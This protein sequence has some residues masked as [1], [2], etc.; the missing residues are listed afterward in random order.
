VL[1]ALVPATSTARDA[2]TLYGIH[3]WGHWEDD[4]IDTEPA[5][6]FDVPE[7]SGWTLETVLTHSGVDWWR[8][9]YFTP[10]YRKLAR[11]NVSIIT[12]VDYSWTDPIPAPTDPNYD[13]WPQQVSEQVVGEL[14]DYS[15]FWKI[16]NEP[17]IVGGEG[18][19]WPDGKIPPEEY[20]KAYR[21]VRAAIHE[22]AAGLEGE[23]VVLL[24]GP[25]PGEFFEEVR[26]MAGN[27]YLE[28]VIDAIP[29][30]EIDG[31]AIHAYGWDVPMFA[32]G[33]Q[34][35][36]E[37]IKEKGLTDVPVFITEFNRQTLEPEEEPNTAEFLRGAFKN[38]HE[39][40]QQPGNIN[41][42]AMC[43]F[44]YDWDQ[45]AGRG[46]TPFAIEHWKNHGLPESHPDNLFRAF[47]D[48]VDLR[49]PAGVWGIR[50]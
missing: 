10:L 12:R 43:W 39:W 20:A 41:I 23:P 30:D 6:L 1:I 47:E 14:G 21:R 48:T 16:G 33:Y 40:N 28:K 44:V 8:P 3:W 25:S 42:V 29:P 9:E 49:Y 35:Q 31:F 37:L 27:E 38:V 15:R 26:W 17:N 22:R 45:Q 11:W 4:P 32:Q 13:L 34:E 7:H 2:D 24:A 50:E 5:R 36:L 19:L 18:T 46:W